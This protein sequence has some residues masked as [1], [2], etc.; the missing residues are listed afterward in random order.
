MLFLVAGSGHPMHRPIV[1]F[2][3]LTLL[4]CSPTLLA[5]G[6]H[7][8]FS[9]ASRRQHGAKIADWLHQKGCLAEAV[10]RSL[11]PKGWQSAKTSTPSSQRSRLP[12]KSPKSF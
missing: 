7:L 8:R 3:V 9:R 6:Y 11:I 2:V 10:S 4:A 5:I 12:S 1:G